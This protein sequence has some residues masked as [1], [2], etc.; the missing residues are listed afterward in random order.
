M[1]DFL[2]MEKIVLNI[3]VMSVKAHKSD[4]DDFIDL[5]LVELQ[6]YYLKKNW[7]I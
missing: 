7:I 4:I 5:P 3:F 1:D 2:I 6:P